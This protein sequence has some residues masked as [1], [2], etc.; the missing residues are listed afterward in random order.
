MELAAPG[1]M[2]FMESPRLTA[3]CTRYL[4]SPLQTANDNPY[5]SCIKDLSATQFWL[6]MTLFPHE[7]GIQAIHASGKRWGPAWT[8][9]YLKAQ[10]QIGHIELLVTSLQLASMRSPLETMGGPWTTERVAYKFVE[11][12]LIREAVIMVAFFLGFTDIFTAFLTYDPPGCRFI[13][14]FFT[15]Y[16]YPAY[17]VTKAV[18][19]SAMNWAQ[20]FTITHRAIFLILW[21]LM[22]SNY[23]AGMDNAAPYG[24]T[25]VAVPSLVLGCFFIDKLVSSTQRAPYMQPIALLLG[26]PG[27]LLMLRFFFSE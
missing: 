19:K 26:L 23:N 15:I 7:C 8:G 25:P 24:G 4:W 12:T 16:A 6:G 21:L 22:F 2:L 1:L 9:R 3:L 27:L 20:F 17:T 5:V 10:M 13:F 18:C 11:V 14:K